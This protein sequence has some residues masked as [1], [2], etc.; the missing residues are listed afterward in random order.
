MIKGFK[1]YVSNWSDGYAIGI[2]YS[3]GKE[4]MHYYNSYDKFRKAL[5]LLITSGYT[6]IK[7]GE[8]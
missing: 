4:S 7:G 5:N 6:Y 1:T 3:T 2:I 8:E